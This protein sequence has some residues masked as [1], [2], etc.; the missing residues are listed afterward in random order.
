MDSARPTTLELT[1]SQENAGFQSGS[2][3]TRPEDA[4]GI[5]LLAKTPGDDSPAWEAGEG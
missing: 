5:L 1:A 4:H 3:P 2:G